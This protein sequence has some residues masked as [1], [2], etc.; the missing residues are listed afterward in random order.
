MD[1]PRA[2][3]PALRVP[4]PEDGAG[5]GPWSTV[6]WTPD[7]VPILMADPEAYLAAVGDDAVRP[8][9]AVSFEGLTYLARYLPTA[10]EP[11]AA[12]RIAVRDAL[13]WHAPL[14]GALGVEFGCSVGAD[15]G[16]LRA[17]C[18]A[19]IGVDGSVVGARAARALC[20]GEGV[21]RL[22]R[23]EGRSFASAAPVV[24]APLDGVT[25]V[26]GNAL[27]PPVHA[28]C[29]DVVMAVNLLDT[30]SE[31][32][33]LL[34]QLDAV[35]RAG[36][37]MLLASP[38]SWQDGVTAPEEQLGGGTVPALAALGSAEAVLAILRGETPLLP[39]LAYEILETIED[40]PWSLRDHARCAFHYSSWLVA[41]R[42]HT[43]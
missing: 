16:S 28:G 42:K 3:H 4:V 22:V 21:P 10:L 9:D 23:V 20:A 43:S 31:P 35:L 32:V 26:V 12:L 7:G 25:V 36:G 38:F 27:D 1:D 5:S 8:L 41:A 34:G 13:A 29:A 11:G 15:L 18:D 37:L 6:R 17:V 24:Q 19:V 14:G 2:P 39:H 30:V 33:N 40:V